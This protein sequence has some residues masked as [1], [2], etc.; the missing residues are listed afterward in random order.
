VEIFLQMGD[1]FVN[2]NINA[3]FFYNEDERK[4]ARR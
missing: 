4:D 2:L 1:K 3:D